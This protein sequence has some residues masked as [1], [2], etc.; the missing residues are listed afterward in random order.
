MF[1]CTVQFILRAVFVSEKI[2][3][4]GN[5]VQCSNLSSADYSFL[6][7]RGVRFRAGSLGAVLMMDPGTMLGLT[8]N[9]NPGLVGVAD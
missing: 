1:T 9:I 3:P 2:S 7:K 5:Y 4:A 8:V 6:V